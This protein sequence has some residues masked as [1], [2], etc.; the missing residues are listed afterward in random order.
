MA[1]DIVFWKADPNFLI[2]FADYGRARMSIAL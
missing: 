2:L 1:P